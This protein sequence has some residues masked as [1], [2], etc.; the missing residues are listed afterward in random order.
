MYKPSLNALQRDI[1]SVFTSTSKYT[2]L[3]RKAR[4]T[5][6]MSV[7]IAGATIQAVNWQRQ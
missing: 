4:D 6:D 5:I 7:G 2:T 1:I 3:K